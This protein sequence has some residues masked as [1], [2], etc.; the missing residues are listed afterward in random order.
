VAHEIKNPLTPVRLG[1]QHLARVHRER[2]QE[3]D[4]VFHETGA[5]IF[6]EID[7]LDTVARAFSRFAAPAGAAPPL[8]RVVLQPVVEEVLALYRLGGGEGPEVRIE[9]APAGP[10]GAR[11]DEVKE[12]LVNLVENARNAGAR[13]ITVSVGP[14]TLA[15]AD[16]GPGIPAERLPHL[17][18]PR[19]STST[20]GAGLG[21]SIVKRLVEGWG[22]EVGV[23][24]RA[25]AGTEV[26][27]RWP[28]LTA[29][30]G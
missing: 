3:F 29:R 7:R 9:A 24:S 12:V 16:D 6:A 4:R 13:V 10:V 18:E 23:T 25:G 5:R 20:S 27:V 11:R 19:F 2:P 26:R 22:A 17:F 21:L 1:L 14:G 28:E 8:D 30:G 15:V